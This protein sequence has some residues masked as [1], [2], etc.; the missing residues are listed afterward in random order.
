M[1]ATTPIPFAHPLSAD[2]LDARYSVD[3]W[4]RIAVYIVGWTTE[5][6]YE[7]DYLICPDDDCDHT[8]S[9]MCWIEG[10]TSLI[11]GEMLRVVMVG[12]DREHIVD[13]EDLV[14]L[15]EDEYCGC[16]GQLGCPWG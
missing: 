1:N 8:A 9:E 14:R 11:D 12:D 16:C 15:D 3:G 5:E 13:P 2:H 7:G 10:D 4:G 6:V